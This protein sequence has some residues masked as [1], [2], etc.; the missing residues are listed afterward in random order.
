MLAE[1]ALTAEQVEVTADL[2]PMRFTSVTCVNRVG[3][4]DLVV[5]PVEARAA[6]GDDAVSIFGTFTPQDSYR[7]RFELQNGATLDLREK[8]AV[9]PVEG[10]GTHTTPLA[11]A[12]NATITIDV[13]GRDFT[14]D[15]KVVSWT[16]APENLSTLKFRFK[17]T[18]SYMSN[19]RITAD[20]IWVRHFKQLI[21]FR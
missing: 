4:V 5:M 15:E 11:F 20:G 17:T 3:D 21:I 10:T 19:P 18:S 2:D 7:A 1:S 6:W 13:T 16:A 9:W 8:T 14:T 12:D